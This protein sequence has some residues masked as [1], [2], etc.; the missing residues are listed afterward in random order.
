MLCFTLTVE[1]LCLDSSSCTFTHVHNADCQDS[2]PSYDVYGM[3]L[4]IV[5][6]CIC[7][8]DLQAVLGRLLLKYDKLQLL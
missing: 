6:H 7:A 1:Y 5:M 2:E 4:S 3:S 8:T